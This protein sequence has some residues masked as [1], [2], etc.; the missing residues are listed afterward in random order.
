MGQRTSKTSFDWSYTEEPHA[1]RRK[2]MLGLHPH[3][4]DLFGVDASFKFVVAA[5]VLA[6]VVIAYL[7]RDA[8]WLHLWL[9]AYMVSGTI[10]H[11]LTLAVHE[12][13]HNMGFGHKRAI[14]VS[15]VKAYD[16]AYA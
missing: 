8:D 1:T 14:E 13:S 12:C 6:Q 10:N 7:L 15:W 5:Q 4:K 9:Q 3:L 16:E 11:S 2:Q